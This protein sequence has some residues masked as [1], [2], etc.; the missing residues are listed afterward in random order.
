MWIKRDDACLGVELVHRKR[1]INGIHVANT[2]TNISS[3]SSSDPRA[4]RC[5]PPRAS[6]LPHPQA[7]TPK[8]G[9]PGAQRP[10]S[11]A[12]LP[13]SRSWGTLPGDLA[14]PPFARAKRGLLFPAGPRGS[15]PNPANYRP[16]GGWARTRPPLSHGREE[17]PSV[18]FGEQSGDSAA[19][20]RPPRKPLGRPF[21]RRLLLSCP[22]SLSACRSPRLPPRLFLSPSDSFSLCL[23]CLSLSSVSFPLCLSTPRL[24]FSVSLFPA[25]LP[26][27]GFNLP[28]HLWVH[29]GAQ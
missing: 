23:V 12:E 11:P 25:S 19:P 22:L 27:S 9:P 4:G 1:S 15:R 6:L 26:W 5:L 17:S 10:H 28:A 13:L 3:D 20:A 21:L 7:W 8:P 24:A 14:T 18:R 2:I 29:L 16:H